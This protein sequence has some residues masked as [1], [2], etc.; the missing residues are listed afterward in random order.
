[1]ASTDSSCG[2]VSRE[3]SKNGRCQVYVDYGDNDCKHGFYGDAAED[4][5]SMGGTSAVGVPLVSITKIVDVFQ[6]QLQAAGIFGA[7][8]GV[9]ANYAMSNNP[10]QVNGCHDPKN[11]TKMLDPLGVFLAN[12]GLRDSFSL[13][14]GT[15]TMPGTLVLGGIDSKHHSGEFMTA[16]VE[17]DS[18]WS[19]SVSKV[20][21]GRSWVTPK[22]SWS[23]IVDSGAPGMVLPRSVYDFLFPEDGSSGCTTDDQCEFVLDIEGGGERPGFKLEGPKGLVTCG[24][25]GKC[26][27]SRYLAR[28]ESLLI[29]HVIQGS[30]YTH[31][32]RENKTIGFAAA[33]AAC[34]AVQK[35]PF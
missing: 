18:E 8:V 14:M 21:V 13:C 25:N 9:G 32:D 4:T 23:G 20:S 17:S 34:T 12:A 6:N 5:V 24:A 3:T 16:D 35:E 33:S 10:G 7:G 30:Y 26:E 2:A 15:V 22:S 11:C 1:M 29:G 31:F 27:P 28:G 19:V